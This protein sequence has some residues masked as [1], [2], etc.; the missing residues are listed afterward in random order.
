MLIPSFGGFMQI[1]PGWENSLVT[2]DRDRQIKKNVF[3]AKI[4]KVH[5]SRRTRRTRR[6]SI[7]N[8]VLARTSLFSPGTSAV[9][10][11]TYRRT[12]AHKYSM[13]RY[14][15]TFAV[16]HQTYQGQE[17]FLAL[18][19]VLSAWYVWYVW[20]VAKNTFWENIEINTF[21]M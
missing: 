18:T 14:V 9:F 7:S 16:F 19:V 21:S 10:H 12:V 11:Q 3:L 8:P 2:I 4:Q 15:G 13:R 17:D 20:Y 5:F 1:T 6:T